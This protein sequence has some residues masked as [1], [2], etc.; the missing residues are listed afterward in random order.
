VCEEV[1]TGGRD[2]G[3]DE[4]EP[5]H[6]EKSKGAGRKASGRRT[7]A[8]ERTGWRTELRAQSMAGSMT[9]D[10]I[11]DRILQESPE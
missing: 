11:D 8:N 3:A 9:E 4:F 1:G 5:G 6:D 2:A 10:C 7:K